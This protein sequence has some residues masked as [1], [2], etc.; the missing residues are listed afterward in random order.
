MKM[1]SSTHMR[2]ESR[3]R[4]QTTSNIYS[5]V[6]TFATILASDLIKPR[7]INVKPRATTERR[8]ATPSNHHWWTH[9][10]PREP[11]ICH[12]PEPSRICRTKSI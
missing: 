8:N 9:K 7:T 5:E 12:G 10:P 4:K 2:R 1:A 3:P 6:W 11:I